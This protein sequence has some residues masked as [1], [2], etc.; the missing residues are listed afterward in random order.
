MPAKETRIS[1]ESLRP[2]AVLYEGDIYDLA[3]LLLKLW[4]GRD[5]ETNARNPRSVARSRPTVNGLAT[6]YSMLVADVGTERVKQLLVGHGFPLG[7]VVD[8]DE[9]ARAGATASPRQPDGAVRPGRGRKRP[10]G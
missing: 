3:R 10:A 8:N 9:G 2:V 6:Y 5:R 1:V 7:A 4:D